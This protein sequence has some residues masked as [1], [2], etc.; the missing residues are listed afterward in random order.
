MGSGTC[1]KYP[2]TNGLGRAEVRSGEMRSSLEH[3]RER[4]TD[5]T[6]ISGRAAEGA[7]TAR[8]KLPENDS[9]LKHIFRKS[10]GHISDTP[11]NRSLLESLANDEAAFKGVDVDGLRWYAKDL[12]DGRQAWVRVCDGV[13]SNGGINNPPRNWT[14]GYGFNSP[15]RK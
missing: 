3:V 15:P 4:A 13:I 2:G 14:E 6:G 5:A 1:G 10:R 8:V 7:A 12:G 9:Q 11:E